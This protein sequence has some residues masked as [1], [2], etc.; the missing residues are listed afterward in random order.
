MTHD[1]RLI[2]CRAMKQYGGSFVKALSEAWLLADAKNM[3]RIEGA[4]PDYMAKYG[5]G[6]AL[7]QAAEQ[8]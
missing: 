1:E 6:S 5:P 3:E 7:H 2:T 4:F 8:I